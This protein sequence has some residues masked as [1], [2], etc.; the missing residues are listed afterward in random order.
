M[1]PGPRLPAFAR[2]VGLEGGT[3]TSGS[4]GLALSS[5]TAVRGCLVPLGAGRVRGDSWNGG[6]GV[7][8]AEARCWVL[9]DQRP[10]ACAF[11][12]GWVACWLLGFECVGPFC[13]EPF[14]PWVG[15]GAGV[16]AGPSV[17]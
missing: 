17:V 2:G 1:G 12:C 15:V 14:P 3:L 8:L 5:S 9:R 11:G 7:G 16:R 13:S 10:S 6:G 4:T